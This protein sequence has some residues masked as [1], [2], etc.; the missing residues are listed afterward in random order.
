MSFEDDP[1]AESDGGSLS[2]NGDDIEL[3]V[4]ADVW[5]AIGE[6]QRVSD[7]ELFGF[8]FNRSFSKNRH[9][10]SFEKAVF[11]VKKCGCVVLVETT[12]ELL[13]RPPRAEQPVDVWFNLSSVVDSVNLEFHRPE[14]SRRFCGDE[15]IKT[16]TVAMWSPIPEPELDLE[17]FSKFSLA[18]WLSGK[19]SEPVSIAFFV[20]AGFGFGPSEG[21]D[22]F[23]CFFVVVDH[24]LFHSQRP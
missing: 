8:D 22:D 5:S 12:L 2:V 14:V 15:Q 19:P 6:W 11:L 4:K 1:I 16:E 10:G 20:R 7:Q 23:D 21:F 17:S 24:C 3:S 18:L 13:A 9:C